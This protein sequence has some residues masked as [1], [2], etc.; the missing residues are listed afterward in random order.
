MPRNIK[1]CTK[2]MNDMYVNVMNV[3]SCLVEANQ[4]TLFS[5]FCTPAFYS[6]V[7]QAFGSI[8]QEMTQKNRI[9]RVGTAQRFCLIKNGHLPSK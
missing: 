8:A 7:P 2:E 4:D 5:R 1:E 6:G 9:R 3:T